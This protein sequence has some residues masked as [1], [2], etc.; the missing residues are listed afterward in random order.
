MVNKVVGKTVTE[1][2]WVFKRHGNAWKLK[3]VL[4]ACEQSIVKCTRCTQFP[5]YSKYKTE[6][7]NLITQNDCLI[8][9]Y[10]TNPVL[11]R[12]T[13][14]RA[15]TEDYVVIIFCTPNGVQNDLV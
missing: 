8:Q 7:S 13:Q 11:N 9:W 5:V 4:A 10:N 6:C 3:N 12:D 15:F 1:T 2:L 14:E